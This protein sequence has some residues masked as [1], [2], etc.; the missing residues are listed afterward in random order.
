MSDEQFFKRFLDRIIGPDLPGDHEGSLF[1]L[2]G[3]NA[4]QTQSVAA[5]NAGCGMILVS[6]IKSGKAAYTDHSGAYTPLLDF[7]E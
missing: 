3:G 6:E 7:Y 2:T 5:K 1:F 4:L